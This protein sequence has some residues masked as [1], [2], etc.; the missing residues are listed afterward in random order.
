MNISLAF[1]R[2]F[3]TLMCVLFLT[4]YTTATAGGGFNFTNVVIGVSS[5][6]GF[7]LALIAADTFLKRYNLRAFNIALLGLLFGY[8]M[9]EAVLLIF[10]TVL[11]VSN[12]P[13]TQETVTLL[14]TTIL[15]FCAYL[16][17]VMTARAAEELHISIPFIKFQA[18]TQK[19]KDILVDW[20]ILTDSRIIDL[21][22][23][24]LLDGHLIMPRFMLKELSNMIEIGDESS[25]AKARRCLE[26]FKKL[27]TTP[28]LE[29]RFSDA[30]FQETKDPVIKLIQLARLL[31]ASIIT[32][33]IARL[34]QATIEG[35]RIINIHMISNAWKPMTGE[36]L[37][38]KIQRYGKEARQ[39]VGYLEDGTM[40]VVNGGAEFIGDTIKAQV[41]SV[42][43]TSSG[44]M[45]F[46]N[47]AEESLSMDQDL[48]Q[49]FPTGSTNETDMEATQKNYFAL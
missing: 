35:I 49:V 17:M 16:G 26:V 29:L 30:D 21:A 33:D 38:I 45:I 14:R 48:A 10:N 18:T 27:E 40:V 22:S 25:R 31:D 19:K 24:G 28:A 4:T 44:R 41:L 1:I 32:A 15:L 2:I 6:L 9:G 11:N 42:K 20:S 46:C 36:H 8:M 13:V 23:S 37:N 39:G 3:F 34:Q 47:A 7:G 12:L 5:G 43:H